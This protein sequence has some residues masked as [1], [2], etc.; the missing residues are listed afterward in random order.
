MILKMTDLQNVLT[1]DLL[2]EVFHRLNLN[3][4]DTVSLME[5]LKELDK[6]LEEEI[7]GSI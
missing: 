2:R 6:V 4:V 5:F 7:N 3:R 1:V